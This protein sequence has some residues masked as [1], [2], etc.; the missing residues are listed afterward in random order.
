MSDALTD[1]H[2]A[3]TWRSA[4]RPDLR[5]GRWTRL[6]D[7]RILGDEATEAVLGRLAE[8]TRAAAQAQ[9]YAVGWAEGHQAALSRGA[10]QA[11]VIAAETER[12]ELAREQEHQAALETL[13]RSAAALSGAAAE[14]ADRI[15]R[16]AGDLALDVISTLLGHELAATT[17]PGAAVIARALAVL[18]DDPTTRVRLHPSIAATAT[19]AE[20]LPHGVAVVADATLDRH[21]VVVETDTSAIDLRI[22]QA[23]DR[24]REALS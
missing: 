5:Q 10:D 16:Q 1:S 11:A 19:P 9:G 21:D 3:P 6:G 14:V 15:A 13:R 7:E 18:P 20:L 4:E 12:R 24:L 2:A 22:S 8:R 23:L 17:D